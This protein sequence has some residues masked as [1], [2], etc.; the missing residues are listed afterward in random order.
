VNGSSSLIPASPRTSAKEWADPAALHE[1]GDREPTEA[2][3]WGGPARTVNGRT[4]GGCIEVLQWILTSG[5]F[6][7]DPGVLDGG[8]LLL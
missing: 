1:Y 6:P 3:S 7:A 8:V 2:W 4:W 5:R